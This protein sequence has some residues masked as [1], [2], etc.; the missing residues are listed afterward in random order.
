ME[1]KMQNEKFRVAEKGI[2]FDGHM[3]N[4]Y[5]FVSNLA[6]NAQKSI[7]LFKGGWYE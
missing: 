5:T 6:W 2:F 7:I 4:A 1:E 3:F